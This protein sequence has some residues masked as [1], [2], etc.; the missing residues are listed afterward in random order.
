MPSMKK[1]KV[2]ALG[3]SSVNSGRAREGTSPQS[4]PPKK[5]RDF[6]FAVIERENPLLDKKKT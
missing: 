3:S 4:F 1:E 6:F 2:D 5:K